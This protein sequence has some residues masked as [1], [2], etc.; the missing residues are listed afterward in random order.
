MRL[1]Y[2]TPAT[3]PG[4]SEP[5]STPISLVL[6]E[7]L[8]GTGKTPT[9]RF[10]QDALRERGLTC[11]A[12]LEGDADNPIAIGAIGP[13]LAGVISR[14]PDKQDVL[15]DWRAL[16]ASCHERDVTVIESRFLQNA[17]MFLLLNG[18][19]D[20]DAA[21]HTGA[22]AD[23]L[24]ATRPL[25]VH[26]RVNDASGHMRT[27]LR[28]DSL[29]WVQRVTAAWDATPWVRARGL[30]GQDGFVE[31]FRQ[32]SETLERL[33]VGLDFECVRIEDARSRWREAIPRLVERI[34]S[35]DAS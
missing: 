14:Y 26:L 18:G 7:G 11:R 5:P 31:F 13:D 19:T 33:I 34:V 27:V 1:V 3:L 16:A 17:A 9:A 15:S 10:L 22:I 2:L 12:Y 25:L 6:I 23:V 30:A 29:E 21:R 20:E 24:R 4:V 8:P 35:K 32:W 28:E